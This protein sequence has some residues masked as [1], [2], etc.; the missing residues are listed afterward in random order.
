LVMGWWRLDPIKRNEI[1]ALCL[2][3]EVRTDPQWKYPSRRFWPKR[4]RLGVAEFERA[5]WRQAVAG[6]VPPAR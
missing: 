4:F 6:G 1:L 5:L 2:D 3:E